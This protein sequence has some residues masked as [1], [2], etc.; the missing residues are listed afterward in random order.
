MKTPTF[1]IDT[2]DTRM[3]Y[4]M[5]YLQ[6]KKYN[7]SSI[8]NN[9]DMG[10]GYYCYSPQKR[11]T[12]DELMNIPDKSDLFC[13][14]LNDIQLHILEAKNIKHH[15]LLSD[16]IFAM[17]NALLT[18]EGTLMLIIRGTNISIF[19]MKIAVLGYGRVG[20]AVS[21]L[22]KGIGTDFTIFSND[23]N[24][25]SM[26]RLL[27]KDVLNLDSNLNDYDVIVN[28]IPA[29]ILP[30]AK[31]K[32]AKKTCYILDLASFSGVEMCDINSL[33]LAYDNALGI[34]GKYSP[35][36]A[37]EILAE[38]ILRNLEV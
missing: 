7:V 19:N 12:N 14:N 30:L 2:S 20:K 25:R 33:G 6:N 27:G 13:G 32:G 4:T 1:V 26:A 23:Y 37:G 8:A 24:E 21:T 36:T 5:R 10:A 35:K 29:K 18:A 31:L 16:E 3:F 9:L 34:P 15:N 11:F 38:A 28:T 22:L 17:D